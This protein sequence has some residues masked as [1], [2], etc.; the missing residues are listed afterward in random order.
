VGCFLARQEIK[1]QPKKT[2]KPT[3]E[4]ELLGQT[5]QSASQKAMRRFNLE[6]EQKNSP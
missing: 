4:R 3:V 2:T 5:A 6:L 1:L